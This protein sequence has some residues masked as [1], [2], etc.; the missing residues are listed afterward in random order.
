MKRYNMNWTGKTL[1]NQM[2]KGTVNFDC[3]VQRGKAWDN[4]R[5]SLLIHSMIYGYSIP[6]LYFVKNENGGYDALDGKQRSTSI[7]DFIEGQYALNEDTPTVC[8]DEEGA[9]EED[10]SGCFFDNLPE[11]C[12][13]AIK[14]YSLTIYY[15]EDMTEDE[16]REFFRRLNNG[17][18]LT[19]IELTR[20]KAKSI[21]VFQRIASCD[22]VVEAVSAK[23][24]E[25]Y[26]D[27]LIGMQVYGMDKMEELDFSNKVFRPW[28]Q[29]EIVTE[30]SEKDVLNGLDYV[31]FMFDH[32]SNALE[33]NPDDR[34]GKRVNKKIRTRTNFVSVA[35][36]GILASRSD[37]D[38]NNFVSTVYNFFNCPTTSTD[39]SYNSSIGAGS[40]KKENVQKRKNAMGKL[41]DIMEKNS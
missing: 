28:I 33:A 24:K 18:P 14:D 32:L 1:A 22:A 11:W 29:Q 38:K 41:V 10:I 30:E 31:K 40:A 17:K 15:Y 20:V 13:D 9:Q 12:K 25:R 7:H 4:E 8:N 39:T 21:D 23:G 37:V 16:I 34:E 36:A 2:N 3:A 6:P 26:T 5:A 35:Y 27:E 19:A